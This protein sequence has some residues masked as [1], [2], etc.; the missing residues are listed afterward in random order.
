LLRGLGMAVL[1]AAAAVTLAKIAVDAPPDVDVITAVVIALL[2]GAAALWS[3][4][5]AWLRRD[6]RGRDWFIAG[7]FAGPVAGVLT[8][9][10]KAVLVDQTGLRELWPALSGGAAFT[11]LL[12]VIP[13]G[14]GLFV[15]GR[16][17]APAGRR[18]DDEYDGR[19]DD[20][21]PVREALHEPRT[22]P[23][24]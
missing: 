22:E 20:E 6:G 17:R 11:A 19:R 5:D 23:A 1:H 15:G 4:I 18:D 7:V 24:G 3:A 10:G 14:L 13:A 16:L 2:V 21:P 12:V 9:A 8:V